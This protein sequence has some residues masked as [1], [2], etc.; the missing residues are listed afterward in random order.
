MTDVTDTAGLAFWMLGP[1]AATRSGV[2]LSLGGRQQRAV[3][4]CLLIEA[5]HPV[6]RSRLSDE[7]WGE[8]LPRGAATTIQTYVSHLRDV[9]EPGR[10]QH[11]RPSVLVTGNGGYRLEVDPARIDSL[12]FRRRVD[13]GRALLRSAGSQAAAAAAVELR[14]A[15]ST[16][17][18]D[19]LSRLKRWRTPS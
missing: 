16:W 13:H 12:V 3:L 10:D 9:L 14:S 18:D 15:L 4:A 2:E 11:E 6:T 5:G 19:A 7:L 1:L 8:H 17:R